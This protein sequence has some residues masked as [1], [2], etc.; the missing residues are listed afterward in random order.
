MHATPV[1]LSTGK[2]R[3]NNL[4]TRWRSVSLHFV[5]S[6]SLP[7]V[8]AQLPMKKLKRGMSERAPLNERFSPVQAVDPARFSPQPPPLTH[9][10]DVIAS[11]ESSFSDSDSSSEE[12]DG[13]TEEGKSRS[14]I[15]IR[16]LHITEV[17]PAYFGTSSTRMSLPSG[18][19]RPRKSQKLLVV[20][21]SSFS[22]KVLKTL[23]AKC[24]YGECDEAKNAKEALMMYRVM[25]LQDSL[26]FAIFVN[27]TKPSVDGAAFIRD[28]RANEGAS[29][30]QRTFVCGVSETAQLDA[31]LFDDCSKYHSVPRLGS[32]P[33]LQRVLKLAA[34]R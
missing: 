6:A 7:D 22:C 1:S 27:M 21:D 15:E 2:Q 30:F 26:Y 3:V 18:P 9:T 8:T 24:G 33:D 32:E 31:V 17:S 11:M 16:Q 20:E 34:R 28:L 5:S 25:A 23:A 13:R 4:S 10:V 14:S 12:R 29:G 19:R